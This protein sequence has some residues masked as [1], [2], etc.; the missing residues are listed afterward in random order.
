MATHTHA[1]T[2][3]RT[4]DLV[5]LE[6]F[7]KKNFL[8]L[9]FCSKFCPLEVFAL[10]AVLQDHLEQNYSTTRHI[11]SQESHLEP[12]LTVPSS[13]SSQRQLYSPLLGVG[14]GSRG[15][16]KHARNTTT[17]SRHL[18]FAFRSL[19]KPGLVHISLMME[20]CYAA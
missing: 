5:V 6:L 18:F 4:Q 14:L 20:H 2:Y 13:S 1:H 17:H 9:I 10:Y 11:I 16:Q 15:R 19:L 3:A 12:S 8:M 7:Q